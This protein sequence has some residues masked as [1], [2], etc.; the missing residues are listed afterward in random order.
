MRVAKETLATE[1]AKA[2]SKEQL[3]KAMKDLCYATLLSALLGFFGHMGI[4]M[5]NWSLKIWEKKTYN[6]DRTQINV[7]NVA[8][9]NYIFLSLG[10]CPVPRAEWSVQDGLLR[11]PFQLCAKQFKKL[12]LVM[13]GVVQP[14]KN[15]GFQRLWMG[16]VYGI[17]WQLGDILYLFNMGVFE[18]GAWTSDL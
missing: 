10:P 4:S 2:A 14:V 5:K 8:G 11:I 6:Y 7:W 17:S 3:A 9:R 15:M 16:R 13:T 1:Q 18:N 12:Q